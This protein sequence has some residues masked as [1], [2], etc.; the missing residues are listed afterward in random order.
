MDFFMAI[1]LCGYSVTVY[2][3]WK[4]HYVMWNRWR[5]ANVNVRLLLAPDVNP[6]PSPGDHH[7]SGIGLQIDVEIREV[8]TPFITTRSDA[9]FRRRSSYLYAN[10][11]SHIISPQFLSHNMGVDKYTIEISRAMQLNLSNNT[12][13]RLEGHT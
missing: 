12:L 1:V 2:L 3:L 10:L 9:M 11:E 7:N 8:I 4:D 5:R 6:V 13:R